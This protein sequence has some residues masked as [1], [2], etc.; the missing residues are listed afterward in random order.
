M[1]TTTSGRRAPARRRHRAA[2]RS[3]APKKAP[4]AKASGGSARGAATAATVRKRGQARAA[5][6]GAPAAHARA[7]RR[8]GGPTSCCSSPARRPRASPASSGPTTAGPSRSRSSRPAASPTP[9]TCWRSTRSQT[10]AHGGLEGYR[11]VRRY[12]RGCPGRTDDAGPSARRPRPGPTVRP[13]QY[14][15]GR[16]RPTSPTSSSG[17]ST[18]GSSSPAT[19]R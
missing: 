6:P 1:A 17:C 13:E 16:R 10:D 3:G 5:G 19:S 15:A 2:R 14:S 11:R 12:V 9:P 18:R 8:P 4:P 7:G